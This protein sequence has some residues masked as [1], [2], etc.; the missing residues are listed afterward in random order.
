M[1]VERAA[2]EK[3]KDER[4]QHA[5]PVAQHLTQRRRAVGEESAKNKM[6]ARADDHAQEDDR[7]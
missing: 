3:P 6:C 1:A 4:A 2:S 7:Y 5:S